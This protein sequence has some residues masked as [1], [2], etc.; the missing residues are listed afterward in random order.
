MYMLDIGKKFQM[1]Y[2]SS[3]ENW[4]PIIK[5]IS[6]ESPFPSGQKPPLNSRLPS[7]PTKPRVPGKPL[8]PT[9]GSRRIR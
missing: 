5:P 3:M 4:R 7:Y 8:R 2:N 1:E 9:R 6:P